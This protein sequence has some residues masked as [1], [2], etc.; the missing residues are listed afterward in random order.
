MLLIIASI[1]ALLVIAVFI[2]VMIG[3]SLP[4]NHVASQ[5]EVL[6]VPPAQ[7]FQLI[8]DVSQWPSWRDDIKAA[9]M[10]GTNTFKATSN[11]DT[12][13]YTISESVPGK[14]LVTTISSKGLPYGGN[15]T[16]EFVAEGNGTRLTVT[17][18]GE[19]YNPFFRFMSKYVFG[20]DGTIK[21]FF[22]N[23]KKK[24]GA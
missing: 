19:V 12:I 20:H 18:N 14:K 9:E 1:I 13:D 15:W 11:G 8:T 23:L 4:Q 3:R 6:P 10:T 21:K 22:V 17:E 24:T 2:S 16:Y 7:L 5:T